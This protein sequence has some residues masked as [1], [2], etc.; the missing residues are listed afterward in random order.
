[1]VVLIMIFSITK[2]GNIIN[3]FKNDFVKKNKGKYR[4][5]YNNKLL[6]LQT[7]LICRDQRAN[8]LKIQLIC[9]NDNLNI[10]DLMK[11]CESLSEFYASK[12]YKHNVFKFQALKF[13]IFNWSIILYTKFKPK[14]KIKIFGENFVKNNRD[15][16]MIMLYNKIFPLQ[17]Y[18]IDDVEINNDFLPIL[19]IEYDIIYDKSFMFHN[20]K[21]LLAFLLPENIPEKLDD[22]DEKNED[23]YLYQN[24]KIIDTIKRMENNNYIDLL[25]LDSNTNIDYLFSNF[26]DEQINIINENF[27]FVDSKNECNKKSLNLT[28][29]NLMKSYLN[30]CLSYIKVPDIT[31]WNT[32]YLMNISNM[33]SGCHSLISIPDIS[34][35]NTKNVTDMK[36]LFY[37]CINLKT[38]PD[39]TKWNTSN[40]T[41]MSGMFEGCGELKYLPDISK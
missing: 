31:S 27:S 29:I 39:L 14:E 30:L 41:D 6:P 11:G 21:Q 34:R 25:N 12:L 10:Y 35:W 28:T 40:V 32:E 4:I 17:E 33:F 1:M 5:I 7:K 24:H 13:F 3:I 8:K 20:C 36:N 9:Y 26:F 22:L 2:K 19:L 37:D 18:L 16:C 23:K 38:I 15:K